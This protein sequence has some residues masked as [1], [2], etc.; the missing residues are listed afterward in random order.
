MNTA[1]LF[2]TWRTVSDIEV[3]MSV[4][5]PGS[6][7]PI[8][9]FMSFLPLKTRTAGSSAATVPALITRSFIRKL[10]DFLFDR[11]RLYFGK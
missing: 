5:S 10:R 7:E 3:S 2:R 1:F 6:N 11:P 4:L 9:V 8:D